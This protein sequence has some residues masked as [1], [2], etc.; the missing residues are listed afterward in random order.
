MKDVDV[1]RAITQSIGQVIGPPSS[2]AAPSAV[3]LSAL[4]T[5]T[6]RMARLTLREADHADVV[7][8]MQAGSKLVRPAMIGNFRR[9][10]PVSD[11]SI[12]EDT[13]PTVTAL[14]VRL[15]TQLIAPGPF[16][17]PSH[18]VLGALAALCGQ[19]AA[20]RNENVAAL[21]PIL[22]ARWKA[23]GQDQV[24]AFQNFASKTKS[25]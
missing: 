10:E 15:Y 22:Q 19:F 1:Q 6:A 2:L 18:L 3:V 24:D 8:M 16:K 20:L 14:L 23:V 7:Q 17:R 5:L 9:G 21:I 11:P 12:P 25:N 4:L 13:D